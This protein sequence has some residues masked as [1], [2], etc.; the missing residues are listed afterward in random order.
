MFKCLTRE[1][2]IDFFKFPVEGSQNKKADM[3]EKAIKILNDNP[4]VLI[5]LYEKFAKELAFSPYECEQLL[6]CTTT[7]RRRWTNDGKLKVVEYQTIN[8]Y[9]RT[10]TYPMFERGCLEALSLEIMDQWRVE[11][12]QD[13][14]VKR[15][16]AQ[17]KAKISRKQNEELRKQFAMEWK[18]TVASWYKQGDLAQAA[19]FELAYWTM[20]LSRWAKEHHRKSRTAIKHSREYVDMEQKFYSMKNEGIK[21]LY[22][23]QYGKLSFYRPVEPDKW[24]VT[25]CPEHFDD[26]KD[27][28]K[29]C[30]LDKW[31]YFFQN[32]KWIKNCKDCV[33]EIEKDYYSLYYLEVNSPVIP[34]YRFSFHTP[35][36]IAQLFFPSPE[37]LPRV[38]H[39]EQKDGLFR[40]GR[41]ILT[42]EKII[43]KEKEVVE[44]WQDAYMKLNLFIEAEATN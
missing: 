9:G 28:R 27:W 18:Q 6:G 14:K 35:F 38:N 24:H 43:Y 30:G 15:I 16:E 31:G 8:K 17:Q 36:P 20:W 2:I 5:S 1:Q 13:L 33:V 40:F 7:E 29:N 37:N 3:V 32:Q 12:E 25:F 22:K 26:F 11:H 10:I 39:K 23:T 4:Q 41:N 34:E 44:K 19:S 21:I 42:E